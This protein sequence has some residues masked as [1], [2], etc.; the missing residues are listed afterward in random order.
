MELLFSI[1]IA[2]S[3]ADNSDQITKKNQLEELFIWKLSDELKLGPS[4]E[5]KFAS[6]VRTLNQKKLDGTLK[7]E[8]TTKELLS[9][10]SEK[11]KESI[12]KNLKK[13][14]QEYNQLSIFELDE[15]KKL[16]GIQRLTNYLEVKQELTAKVK[17]LLIQ[18]NDEREKKDSFFKKDLPPPK[19]IEDEK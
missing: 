6:L 5:K 18:K 4:E 1:L 2:F 9:A 7:I 15:M 11:D 13:A 10:K 12:L 16:L 19:I 14:Y 17:S 3:Y 8:Q